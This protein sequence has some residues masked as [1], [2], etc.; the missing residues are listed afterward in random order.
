[1]VVTRGVRVDWSIDTTKKRAM[2][3]QLYVVAKRLNKV[4]TYEI[5]AKALG[6]NE[7]K[8]VQQQTSKY[9]VQ[10]DMKK[11]RKSWM[12][13]HLEKMN[14]AERDVDDVLIRRKKA[15]QAAELV[16]QSLA[17]TGESLGYKLAATI[18]GL[19]SDAK[20]DVAL[21]GQHV[22]ALQKKR[23]LSANMTNTRVGEGRIDEINDSKTTA[24]QS[25]TPQLSNNGEDYNDSETINTR[26]EHSMEYSTI[27]KGEFNEVQN[28]TRGVCSDDLDDHEE[29]RMDLDDHEETRMDLDDINRGGPCRN[30]QFSA[31]E[32]NQLMCECCGLGDDWP[33]LIICDCCKKTGWHVYCLSPKLSKVP[34][35]KWHCPN[36][37]QKQVSSKRVIKGHKKRLRSDDDVHRSTRNLRPRRENIN[38]NVD[39]ALDVNNAKDNDEIEEDQVN[40]SKRPQRG[41]EKVN[42]NV[43][44][45]FAKMF[46]K[47]EDEKDKESTPCLICTKCDKGDDVPKLV[48]CS[49]EKCCKTYHIYCL[50]P[51]LSYMPRNTSKWYCPECDPKHRKHKLKPLPVDS[52]SSIFMKIQKGEKIGK[53]GNSMD[54]FA[55]CGVGSKVMTEAGFHTIM[56]CEKDESCR[57][58]LN[59]VLPKDTAI[60]TDMKYW[61]ASGFPHKVAIMA[62]GLP[63]PGHSHVQ[64]MQNEDGMNAMENN[65]SA[66]GLNFFTAL[67]NTHKDLK[68]DCLFF[69]CTQGILE[70][71]DEAGNKHGF[72]RTLIDKLN[73]FGYSTQWLVIKSSGDNAITGPR[74]IM[75]ANK[76][77]LDPEM[78]GF[79]KRGFKTTWDGEL[80]ENCWGLDLCDAGYPATRG[81]FGCPRA[82]RCGTSLLYMDEKKDMCV[83][84]L[85]VEALAELSVI[86]MEH[87]SFEEDDLPKISMTK[88]FEIIGNASR[89]SVMNALRL[90]CD[91]LAKALVA[92]EARDEAIRRGDEVVVSAQN[93]IPPGAVEWKQLDKNPR[94]GFSLHS[95]SNQ[96]EHPKIYCYES[97]GD[98]RVTCYYPNVE[99]S[100]EKRSAREFIIKA[101]AENNA[102]KW[103][104]DAVMLYLAKCGS[105]RGPRGNRQFH[106]LNLSKC[107]HN[108][109]CA[110][111]LPCYDP[112]EIRLNIKVQIVSKTRNC[113]Q[114]YKQG[115]LKG[116]KLGGHTLC[117]EKEEHR[118]F[119]VL[120]KR[121][122]LFKEGVL[123]GK[124]FGGDGIVMETTTHDGSDFSWETAK[125]TVES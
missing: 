43:D 101:L 19:N 11:L 58:I 103:N 116:N 56:A 75:V 100:R 92:R 3:A 37:P 8:A 87:L 61:A 33:N 94:A 67:L 112:V 106:L 118:V 125:F 120:F 117:F 108:N 41:Q 76:S 62:I 66:E 69:E 1:M 28:I 16:L 122:G 95:K 81:Q 77:E 72:H 79:L 93:N 99:E 124:Q 113:P 78:A 74:W 5:A 110:W 86:S 52:Y 9:S 44:D 57:R 123:Y 39:Y 88:Q 6:L 2:A 46:K 84:E 114:K 71:P 10:T 4:V 121:D 34:T 26:D 55:G 7:W 85:T 49:G 97:A 73:G 105:G 27:P 35:G 21:I 109:E 98:G 51:K 13:C 25:E 38:Y 70:S 50:S 20:V 40:N 47:N 24:D 64:Q 90:T 65:K 14:E 54:I 17:T 45:S 59:S 63:C 29:T 89:Y 83:A 104:D 23:S 18:C 31:D 80:D 53:H 119:A 30:R 107:I 12:K 48:S 91:T 96:D 15:N 22:R 60:L 102:T 36:C 68:P 111:K 115:V 32:I 42:Y 82:K